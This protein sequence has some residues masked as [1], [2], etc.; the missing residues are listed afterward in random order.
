MKLLLFGFVRKAVEKISLGFY[1]T[2]T[3]QNLFCRT[4]V[5]QTFHIPF[6]VDFTF[7]NMEF[8]TVC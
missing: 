8:G 6:I 5:N 1:D 2:N 4:A 7:N 3:K